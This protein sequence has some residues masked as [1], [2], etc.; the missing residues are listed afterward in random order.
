MYYMKIGDITAYCYT[1]AMRY[2][3]GTFIA[4]GGEMCFYNLF[5][6]Y[7]KMPRTFSRLH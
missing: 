2:A 3:Q 5:L 7:M 1:Y 6:R 4:E